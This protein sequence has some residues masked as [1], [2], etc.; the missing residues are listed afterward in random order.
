MNR[1]LLIFFAFVNTAL[2]QNLVPN[3]GFENAFTCPDSFTK[4]RVKDLL[5]GW[6]VPNRGTPDYFNKCSLTDV[7]VPDNFAG[8]ME[9]KNGIGYIG[10]I[11]KESFNPKAKGYD[12]TKD[13][14]SREY[15]SAKLL[16]PLK[17]TKLYCVSFYFCLAKNSDYAVDG[18]GIYFSKD[19][20]KL[21]N[22]G[23]ILVKPQ[24]KNKNGKLLKTKIKWEEFCGVIQPRGGE[25]FITIGN[26]MPTKEVIYEKVDSAGND[27]M[28]KYAYYLIDNVKVYA[29]E[30][31]FECGCSGNGTEVSKDYLATNKES[32]K[33]SKNKNSSSD[34]SK[35]KN[36]DSK[37]KI[38]D[39]DK[40]KSNKQNSGNEKN[41]QGIDN[42]KEVE[43]G[44]SVTM[45][46]IFFA[47]KEA[48]LTPESY[49]EL[50]KLVKLMEENPEM[51]I[52]ISGFT[53]NT[54]SDEFNMKLSVE[55]A[56]AV[57]DYLKSKKIK[58][59]RLSCKGFGNTMPVVSNDTEEGRAKN[60]RV[61]FRVIK[62]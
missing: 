57:A 44:I 55:R 61:E 35:N 31:D 8:S 60:R 42:I 25:K 9:A 18:L 5:P 43:E 12:P 39:K 15:I 37:N 49:T 16:K 47:F 54:G 21:K 38:S 52:E 19:K 2:A 32:D 17:R 34:N 24:I 51:E 41:I 14:Y 50:D 11:L 7:G 56:N 27:F 45:N 26:F 46:N 59:K 30:N 6:F 3:P 28:A 62:K 36:T 13:E 10:M 20:V 4:E 33:N 48:A 53:D 1:F 23:A 58:K 29:I 40:N 22:D